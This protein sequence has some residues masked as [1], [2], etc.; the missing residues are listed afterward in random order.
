MCGI[1]GIL[2][3]SALASDRIGPGTLVRQLKTTLGHRG[4]DDSGHWTDPISHTTLVHTRLAIIDLTSAGHQ[5]MV[6]E[7]GRYVIVFN[8]EIYNYRELRQALAADAV[9]FRTQSDTEVILRLF[10]RYGADCLAML[11]GMFAFCI[12]DSH[13]RSALLARDR[14]GIKPLYYFHYGE[15]L[16]F[17]SEVRSLLAT[18][19]VPL[20]LHGPGLARYF[21][22][23]SIGEP[24][25]LLEGVRSLEAGCYLRWHNG[26]EAIHSFVSA[27][28][29]Q[30]SLAGREA[31]S[32]V[33]HALE[34]SVACHFV[35]DVPVGIFLSGG[36]DSTGILA[37]AKH[38]FPHT[39]LRTF[40]IS[41][42]AEQLDE[43][44]VA[45]R[46]AKTFHT[47]HTTLRM[48][49]TKIRSVFPQFLDALDLPSIDGLNTWLV[50]SMARQ[51]GMKVVLSGLGGD[52]LFGGYPSF[53]KVPRMRSALA[54]LCHSSILSRSIS[55]M[56][57]DASSSRLRR[58]GSFLSGPPTLERAYA[59]WR[60]VFA[61]HD[62]A[63]LASH[64]TGRRTDETPNTL[65]LPANAQEAISALE[66]S[67]YMRTQLL[68]DSD[69][70]SMSHGL[71]LRVP[72]V[73]HQLLDVLSRV[74]PKQRFAA[75]K[76]LL[77]AAI[78]ELPAE[79]ARA[80]KRG[81]SL[82]YR[83]WLA[84]TDD[85]GVD[86]D[87][88]SLPVPVTDWYQRWCVI[89]FLR[90]WK[91]AQCIARPLAA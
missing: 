67:Q 56:L 5:P 39:E 61:A 69:V 49:A 33:R 77:V 50:S 14:F 87:A 58:L 70:M 86:V 22:C 48:D 32:E 46:T 53:S 34:D 27:P 37:L 64:F 72:F 85:L 6:S 88:Q 43:G 23:G 30:Y 21:R 40:S 36:I 79:V 81:F 8:G 13:E 26:K 42:D 38:I 28:T 82:P 47:Q 90:W 74:A 11:R 4:P 16:L 57:K 19:L 89:T 65:A 75:N 62:A 78:P 80:P 41:V 44:A 15:S 1:G 45:C 20:V 68:R 3:V 60:G 9:P 73:D 52:E 83:A 51:A 59:A 12:W 84:S 76:E 91:A 18:G 54:P 7:D 17:A 24:D 35:S 10:E 29:P 31:V 25:T 63:E 71:E 2:N 66:L 55:R